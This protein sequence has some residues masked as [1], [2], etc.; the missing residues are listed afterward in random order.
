M[1]YPPLAGVGGGKEAK[2]ETNPPKLFP[3][4]QLSS[5]I[6]STPEVFANTKTSTPPAGY[7]KSSVSA[8]LRLEGILA[9]SRIVGT[10]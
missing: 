9:C 7:I 3:I 5:P 2:V 4:L 8:K 10:Q 1:K 6:L